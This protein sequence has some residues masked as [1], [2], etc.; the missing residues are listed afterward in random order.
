LAPIHQHEYD[1]LRRRPDDQSSK[2][3]SIASTAQQM[4]I[5][6]EIAGGGA[7][8]GMV[9]SRQLCLNAGGMIHGLHDYF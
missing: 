9:H 2:T 5:S 3:S 8:H 6:F 7:D 1:R 4:S